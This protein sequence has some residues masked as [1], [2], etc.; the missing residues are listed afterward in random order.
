[1]PY[2]LQFTDS[3]RFTRS[4]LLNLVNNLSERIHKIKCKY[5]SD[6]KNVKLV[7]LNILR[8]LS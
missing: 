4:S 6:D 5:G 3:A 7:E 8:L 2:R 1:M